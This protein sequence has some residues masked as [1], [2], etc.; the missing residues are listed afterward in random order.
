MSPW[1]RWAGRASQFIRIST[2]GFRTE[3]VLWQM[4]TWPRQ[5][6]GVGE[7]EGVLVGVTH[8][9]GVKVSTNPS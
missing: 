8:S 1:A 2:Y 5:W 9:A 7:G 4:L 6:L 3:L